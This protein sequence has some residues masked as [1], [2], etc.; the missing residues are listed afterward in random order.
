MSETSE[1][2]HAPIIA[3]LL[4]SADM[5]YIENG[6]RQVFLRHDPT[7]GQ[8]FRGELA[9]CGPGCYVDLG[10]ILLEYAISCEGCG[11]RDMAA[12]KAIRFGERLAHSLVS[13]SA[14]EIGNEPYREK[15]QFAFRLILNSMNA[16]YTEDGEPGRLE[17][18]LSCCPL[19]ECAKSSGFGLGQEIAHLAFTAL[20]RSLTAALAPDWGLV[21]PTESE[22]G[23]PL[24]KI[25]VTNLQET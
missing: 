20:C 19:S 15:L 12:V 5:R 22:K 8:V 16:T 13:N 14:K 3:Y 7:L 18:S 10:Q 24:R 21:Q 4:A 9:G 23:T 6:E 11:D 2:P 25:V 17:Y 1:K